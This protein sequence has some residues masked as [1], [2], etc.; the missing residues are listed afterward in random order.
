MILNNLLKRLEQLVLITI[1]IKT[2]K[3]TINYDH[4]YDA[5]TIWKDIKVSRHNWTT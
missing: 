4:I 5:I 2:A 3:V 1:Q